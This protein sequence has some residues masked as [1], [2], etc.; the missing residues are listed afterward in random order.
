MDEDSGG[1][2]MVV[3]Q[4]GAVGSSLASNVGY[5]K[6]HLCADDSFFWGEDVRIGEI[7]RCIASP[8]GDV[9]TLRNI[10]DGADTP[11]RCYTECETESH[12]DCVLE[13]S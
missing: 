2:P 13:F 4:Q 6:L 10:D 1:Q 12:W 8:L 3:D 9:W 11:L 7:V 5:V